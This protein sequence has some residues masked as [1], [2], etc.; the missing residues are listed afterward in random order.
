MCLRSICVDSGKASE[1]LREGSGARGA[2]DGG[3]AMGGLGGSLLGG[4]DG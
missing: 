1:T 3:S 2:S 4:V